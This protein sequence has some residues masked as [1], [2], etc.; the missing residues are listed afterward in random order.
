M[1]ELIEVS[2]QD[3]LLDVVGD[4]LMR[5]DHTFANPDFLL[6]LAIFSNGSEA[7]NPSVGS[8]LAPPG[9]DGVADE[10]IVVDLGV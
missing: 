8:D 10:G 9:D 1:I 3:F 7:L 2:H 6:D 4:R 5:A